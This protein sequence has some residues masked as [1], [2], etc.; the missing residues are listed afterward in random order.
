MIKG[1]CKTFLNTLGIA[2][3]AVILVLCFDRALHAEQITRFKMSDLD[4]YESTA[5]ICAAVSLA[6]ADQLDDPIAKQAALDAGEYW[7]KVAVHIFEVDEGYIGYA[8]MVFEEEEF[9]LKQLKDGL[10]D[11]KALMDKLEE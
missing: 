9:T 6:I 3:L 8:H 4:T 2:T 5:V 11:C 1:Y 10:K 7:I